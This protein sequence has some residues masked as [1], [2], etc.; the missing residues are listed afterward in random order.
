MHARLPRSHRS[1]GGSAKGLI[2]LVVLAH[3]VILAYWGEGVWGEVESCLCGTAMLQLQLEAAAVP[4]VCL[5]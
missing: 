4:S 5:P 2:V 3:L 1:G